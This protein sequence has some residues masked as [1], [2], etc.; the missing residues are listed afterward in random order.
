MKLISRFIAS[1][2]SL[3]IVISASAY[4][5][6]RT[7]WNPSRVQEA[8]HSTGAANKIA[9]AIPIILKSNLSL[10]SDEQFI[11]KTV[12]TDQNVSPLLDQI[13]SRLATPDGTPVKLDLSQFRNQIAAEGLP[14][15]KGL[16]NLTSKPLIIISADVSTR[17]ASLKHSSYQLKIFGPIL[18][19]ILI[20]LIFVLAKRQ[21]FLVLAEAGTFAAIE[22]ALLSILAPKVPGFAASAIAS[23]N[24]SPLKDTYLALSGNLATSIKQDFIL[25]AEIAAGISV[26][27]F[28]IHGFVLVRTKFGK[29]RHHA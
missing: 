18:A 4:I 13:L 2:L 21:R 15:T 16:D 27:L 6:S 12:S 5:V 9:S 10:T 24:L 29:S 7:L 17:L 23:S 20:V 14:L 8:A 22:L 11:V 1:V 25:A 26:V 19:I 28:L 3:V